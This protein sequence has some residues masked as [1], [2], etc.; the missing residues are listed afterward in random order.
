MAVVAEGEGGRV[1]SRR[2]QQESEAQKA[3]PEWKPDGDVPAR[4]TGGTCVPHGLTTWGD[5][6][7]AR[8]LVTLTTLSSLVAEARGRRGSMQWPPDSWMTTGNT[9]VRGGTGAM[10]YADAV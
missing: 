4:L 7:T 6:F 3:T 8:Q 9:R 10:A 2:A 5:L 1:Y